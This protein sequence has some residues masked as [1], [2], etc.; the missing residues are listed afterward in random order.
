MQVNNP[1][2]SFHHFKIYLQNKANFIVYLF[3]DFKY[4]IYRFA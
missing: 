2:K 4:Y 1:T 3:K